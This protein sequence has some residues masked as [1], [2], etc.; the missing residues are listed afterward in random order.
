VLAGYGLERERD[1]GRPARTGTFLTS[2]IVPRARALLRRLLTHRDSGE[3]VITESFRTREALSILQS[4]HFTRRANSSIGE[5][6][7]SYVIAPRITAHRTQLSQII[8]AGRPHSV[9]IVLIAALIV[10][11]CPFV[12]AGLVAQES[13]VDPTRPIVVFVHGLF[14]D[15]L[16]WGSG[17]TSFPN[18]VRHDPSLHDYDVFVASYDSRCGSHSTGANVSSSLAEQLR[19]N[20]VFDHNRIIFVAHSLGGILVKH[21]FLT[22]LSPDEKEHVAGVITLG[23]PVQGSPLANLGRIFCPNTQISDLI[24]ISDNSWLT[25][26]DDQWTNASIHQRPFPRVSC[27]YETEP[28]HIGPVQTRVVPKEYAQAGY[29]AGPMFAL[30]VN[31]FDLARPRGY[32]SQTYEWVHD[33]IGQANSSPVSCVS[34]P[35]PANLYSGWILIGLIGRER[36]VRVKY[37]V[38]ASGP[39]TTQF[40]V[41][42]VPAEGST[43][44]LTVARRLVIRAFQHTV[45]TAEAYNE[46]AKITPAQMGYIRDDDDYTGV[47][48]CGNTLLSIR[49]LSEPVEAGGGPEAYNLWA[50]VAR[51][52]T[53]SSPG[54]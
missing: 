40:G 51:P 16:S 39:V 17:P 26:I 37:Y 34:A 35:W 6:S 47:V 52:P 8:E 20:R 15:T 5:E 10:A 29:C 4:D 21:A 33:R 30:A 28:V 48:I 3:N 11:C 24:P 27:A 53:L 31:H 45:P 54:P 7:L 44:R 18:L 25:T 14:G 19:Y 50:R 49:Q 41:R 22:Y 12:G 46:A 23:T 2:R 38:M 13:D 32:S 43:I 1:P 36:T 42:D 9:R